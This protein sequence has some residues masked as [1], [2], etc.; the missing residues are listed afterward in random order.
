MATPTP[1]T[2]ALLA[3]SKLRGVGTATLNSLA[4]HAAALQADLGAAS[5]LARPVARALADG[6]SLDAARREA[7]R[8]LARC[9]ALGIQVLSPADDD[10]PA[11]L[12]G[13]RDRSALLFVRGQMAT[14]TAPAVAVI[15]T[16]EPTEHGRAIAERV[17]SHFARAGWCI[18]SG[19]A[20]GVDATAHRTAIDARGLTVAVLAHGL[21]TVSPRGH[22]GLAASILQHGGA[23]LSEYPPGAP[24]RAPQFVRRDRVQAALSA[25]VVLVQTDVEGG[26]LHAS[27]AALEYGRVLAYPVP[28]A[29]DRAAHAPK[30]RGILKLMQDAPADVAAYLKCDEIALNRIIPLRS[31]D[32]Y[33]ALERVLRSNLRTNAQ[34]EPSPQQPIADRWSI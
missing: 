9:A 28:T 30:V 13:V 20:L 3:L 21:D 14:L 23:L 6:A 7:D 1:A 18:V 22:A 33:A 24:V 5:N 10:Y 32:D 4:P 16:R 17:T 2:Y 29:R 11:I 8:D 12:R 15:G 25:G 34:V 27:R 31:R 19:L 26:S